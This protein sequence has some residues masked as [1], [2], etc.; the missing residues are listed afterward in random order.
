[1]KVRS[2]QEFTDDQLR[3]ELN[4]RHRCVDCR[5]HWSSGWHSAGLNRFRCADCETK[6]KGRKS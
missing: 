5:T 1:M 4:E 2:I 6:K 3:N